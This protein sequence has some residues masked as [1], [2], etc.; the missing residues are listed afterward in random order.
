MLVT[1]NTYLIARYAH[2]VMVMD[3]SNLVY[4]GTPR[5]LFKNLDN[6]NTRAID[7]PEMLKVVERLNQTQERK[8]QPFLTVDELRIALDGSEE[9]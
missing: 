1:H 6:V 9:N 4:D 5:D 8:M 3:K 7:K 2:Q